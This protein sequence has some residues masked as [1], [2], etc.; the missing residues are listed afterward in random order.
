MFSLFFIAIGSSDNRE[1]F[2][3]TC[4]SG[5]SST[6]GREKVDTSY[7]SGLLSSLEFRAFWVAFSDEGVLTVGKG[8]EDASFLGWNAG[9]FHDREYPEVHVGIGTFGDWERGDWVFHAFC[10]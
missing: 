9:M 7:E 8:G 4:Y 5:D 6:C 1:A 3:R 2:I 10:E